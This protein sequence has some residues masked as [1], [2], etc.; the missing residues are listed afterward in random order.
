MMVAIGNRIEKVLD[1][2][3]DNRGWILTPE[4]KGVL[5]SGEATININHPNIFGGSN[6]EGG[7]VGTLDVKV[8]ADDQTQNE[9]LAN[10][11]DP[12]ISAYPNLSYLTFRG[13]NSLNSGF[14]VVSMSG[15]LKDFLLWVK[16]TRIKNNGSVQWFDSHILN[17]K[18]IYPPEIDSSSA[19]IIHDDI[20]AN[21]ESI[22][23]HNQHFSSTFSEGFGLK[24]S[25]IHGGGI[26]EY[27][28][29]T[30]QFKSEYNSPD[31]IMNSELYISSPVTGF[32]VDS[33]PS[34]DNR[35]N[36]YQIGSTTNFWRP[37]YEG[38]Y[39]EYIRDFE[40][41][42]GDIVLSMS[43]LDYKHYKFIT[44][45]SDIALSRISIKGSVVSQLYQPPSGG[46]YH[47]YKYIIEINP[48]EIFN[49]SAKAIPNIGVQSWKTGV[50]YSWTLNKIDGKYNPN[51]AYDINPI[52]KIREILTDDTAMNKLE[53]LIN[54]SNFREIALRIYNEQLGISWCIQEKSCKDALDELCY[55]I[56]GGL[57][58]NRQT[59]LYEIILFRDDMLDLDNALNFNESNIKTI[60]FD[61]ANMDEAISSINVS[62]YDRELIK[63]SSF[64][65][66]ENGL[67]RTRGFDISDNVDFPYFMNRTNAEKIGNWK[68]K[69]LST[70]TWKG[71]FKTGI[72]EARKLNKYDV[73]K[74]SW[75]NKNLVDLP[76]RVMNINL[77]DG[78]NNTVT[79]EFIEVI[80]YSN[81]EY[82]KTEV[83]DPIDTRLP[84]QQNLNTAFEMPY[85]EAV[86]NFTQTQVDLELSNTPEIGYLMA[87][88]QKPQ[89]NSLNAVLYT[90]GATNDSAQFQQSGV[91]NYCPAVYLDQVIGYTENVF[92]IKDTTNATSKFSGATNG[93]WI[94]L[95]DEIMVYESF[96]EL[97]NEITVKRGALDTVPHKH[98][99][100]VIFF[101]D[102]FSGLDSTQYIQGEEVKYQVLTTTQSAIENIDFSSAKNVSFNAREIRPYP[103]ANVKING[104]YYPIEIETDLVI[105]W[106]D[107]NRLQQ[108]GGNIMGWFDGGITIEQSTSTKIVILEEDENHVVLATHNNDVTGT[109]SYTLPIS[110]LDA[111][112]RYLNITA[113]TIRDGFDSY[114][115]F[116]HIVE[117]SL[118]FSAPYDLTVEFKN[119]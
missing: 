62:Y 104:E 35:S 16:R 66:Y 58:I 20:L 101:S 3:P 116:N 22:P 74:L 113:R 14:E 4:Q 36:T 50:E 88:A 12:E 33:T 40:N 18:T 15:M 114:Q 53:S 79:I 13:L 63:N 31:F 60:E 34:G 82:P 23:T 59:G 119:D 93:T 9:Y 107:R 46:D 91:V 103:P 78:I 25:E 44:I 28:K 56:E 94:I 108:T 10:Q 100:G 117:I 65:L 97:T 5:N 106:V 118:F 111:N 30:S 70:P 92:K 68:L 89:N 86:Q 17:G 87:S 102:E 29:A 67:Q 69:Q 21:N 84:P 54:D 8:G 27:S 55:H 81:I 57:R 64:L 112:T 98:N 48:D 72:T 51:T 47:T 77:G 109:T 75:L 39:D 43:S 95:N 2:N 96:N 6:G 71:S 42:G 90:D 105:T 45:R 7:W 11:I 83:D 49:F 110:S 73:I 52:H 1:I 61:I 85:F 19:V 80:P 24:E 41:N 99:S 115:S 38:I 26:Y 76:V 32:R 37:S